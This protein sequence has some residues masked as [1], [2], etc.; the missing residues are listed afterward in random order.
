MS[1]LSRMA[2]AAMQGAR[3]SRTVPAVPQINYADLIYTRTGT[4]MLEDA[5]AGWAI[6]AGVSVSANVPPVFA[7]GALTVEPAFTN[8]IPDAR[9]QDAA[10][11]GTSVGQTI[12]PGVED[13][14]DGGSGTADRVE[15]TSGGYH[16][17]NM[18]NV[19]EDLVL[20]YWAKAGAG[21]V[22][23]HG[24]FVGNGYGSTG[25]G[26]AALTSSWARFTVKHS[27]ATVADDYVGV[28]G[29]DRSAFGGASAG[30]RDAIVDL[31]QVIVGKYA[32]S[33]VATSGGSGGLGAPDAVIPNANVAASFFS[34]GTRVS[35]W[36]RFA[37][38]DAPTDAFLAYIDADNHLVLRGSTLR[39]RANAVNHEVTGLSYAEHEELEVAIT[40]AGSMVVTGGGG[41]SVALTEDW[42]VVS[43]S[44]VQIGSDATPASHLDGMISQWTPL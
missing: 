37:V 7:D 41:G 21:Y 14:P 10:S 15:T 20:T 33:T 39:L 1:M 40:W 8:V 25:G 11:W 30:A 3:R 24:A 44:D 26:S 35:I 31:C 34:T 16:L 28:D 13:G 32:R 5:R 9:A 29:T 18:G 22:G 2:A 6:E 43:S 42:S 12:T 27:S 36:P 17:R 23:P 19:A 4:A 38:A